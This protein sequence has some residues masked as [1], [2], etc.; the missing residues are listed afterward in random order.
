MLEASE[1]VKCL[2]KRKHFEE[3]SWKRKQ[4]IFYC[5]HK[6]VWFCYSVFFQNGFWVMSVC[7]YW[8]I[9][10]S[11]KNYNPIK[12]QRNIV[13]YSK[14]FCKQCIIKNQSDRPQQNVTENDYERRINPRKRPE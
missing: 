13:K 3:R 5:F 4:K 10:R 11:I 8:L 6:P 2:W 1:A 9:L 12:I 14:A 7:R